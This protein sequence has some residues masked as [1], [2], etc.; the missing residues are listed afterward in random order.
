MTNTLFP[1]PQIELSELIQRCEKQMVEILQRFGDDRKY[2]IQ[3]VEIFKLFYDQIETARNIMVLLHHQRVYKVDVYLRCMI[4]QYVYLI[5]VMSDPKLAERYS[6]F[7]TIDQGRNDYHLGKYN[8]IGPLEITDYGF[9][10]GDFEL[11][12]SKSK[13]KELE[14]Q[15][16]ALFPDKAKNKIWFNLDG[17]TTTLEKLTK[18]LKID[19][20]IAREYARLSR[21]THSNTSKI[22]IMF[23][24]K[25]KSYQK[26]EE[27][28]A[29][30]YFHERTCVK[31]LES[32]DELARYYG[33]IPLD[34]KYSKGVVNTSLSH[35]VTKLGDN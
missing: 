13:L 18:K 14:A 15:Y 8:F 6:L 10:I 29:I 28:N 3:D 19:K 7:K 11:G 24:M 5:A 20:V 22:D 27:R 2:T 33:T 34:I 32:S 17:K 4:E 23:I 9:S 26:I 1:S 16:N 25:E 31:L 21:D 30:P 12:I 35:D